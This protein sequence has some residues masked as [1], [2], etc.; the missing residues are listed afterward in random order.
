MLNMN[1]KLKPTGK[2]IAIIIALAALVIIFA[3]FAFIWGL[4]TLFPVLAIPYSFES[5]LAVFVINA[6]FKS[7]VSTN[8]D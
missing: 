5:W 7:A 3:P 6:F 8:K 1:M 4:N 2:N